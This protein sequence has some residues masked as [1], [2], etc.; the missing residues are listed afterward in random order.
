MTA[1]SKNKKNGKTS[2][3]QQVNSLSP[4]E[5]NRRMAEE[6]AVLT[7]LF[8]SAVRGDFESL[9][10]ATDSYRT[11]SGTPSSPSYSASDV[12][13]QFR[14]GNRRTA[15]HFACQSPSH[16]EWRRKRGGSN[17]D[18]D[19]SRKNDIVEEILLSGW[20]QPPS[21]IAKMLRMKDK[22]GLTPLM[23][24]AQAQVDRYLS[25]ERI[26]AILKADDAARSPGDAKLGL[27]RSRVGATALHYA[28]G[29]W[30]TDVTVN[31]LYEAGNAALNTSSKGGG[32]PLHWACAVPPPANHSETIHA[33]V[34]LGANINW[35]RKE[36]ACKP[37]EAAIPPPLLVALAAGNESHAEVLLMFANAKSID[38]RPTLDFPL[39]GGNRLLHVVADTNMHNFL[40][41]L[42][43]IM[44]V[45]NHDD[46]SN[47]HGGRALFMEQMAKKNDDG[48]A[49]LGIAAREG[50]VECVR[51][52][53][54]AT[55]D[56]SNRA[57]E[58]EAKAYIAEY[59]LK[60]FATS[61]GTDDDKNDKPAQQ[62]RYG[63][64]SSNSD[65]SRQLTK[66]DDLEPE[67]IEKLASDEAFRLKSQQAT[68][69][70]SD[71][72]RSRAAEFK[73]RGNASFAGKDYDAAVRLYTD[74][75][76]ADPTDATYYSNRSACYMQL[77]R[78]KSALF[79]AV[80]SR[81]LK[82]DWS[83]AA[84]RM[85]VARSE[86]GLYEDAAVAA[87]EGLNTDP[88]SDELKSLF[89]KCVKKGRKEHTSKKKQQEENKDAT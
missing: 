44:D 54:A 46:N 35:H 12:L 13:M 21:E 18:D 72:D 76:G 27:A 63:S 73:S 7:R 19:G 16:K 67:M 47:R 77:R 60:R 58:E 30:A 17:A 55:S 14:D 71:D 84:F 50:H 29:A 22:D 4:D 80:V 43:T 24:A 10:D 1:S 49:P 85:A 65:V 25:E 48:F 40:L 3:P 45:A 62:R 20:L 59:Q 56:S 26:V 5:Q 39:R 68:S 11:A 6:R 15:L 51:W 88:D 34:N 28:S 87:F 79:D 42:L 37:G 64:S 66:I 23:L 75:I 2:Q 69:D 81:M 74:A 61:T 52:F 41:L 78:P 89:Q 38:I 83:K 70:V 86:L 33:L 32:T 8:E 36:E 9:R 57:T 82:P 53:L 31:A